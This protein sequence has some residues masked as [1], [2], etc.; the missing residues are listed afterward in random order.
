MKTVN[1][2]ELRDNLKKNLEAVSDNEDLLIVHRPKGKSIV[3]MSLNEFNSLQE[4]F[5]LTRSAA[6]RKRLDAAVENINAR[7]NLEQHNLID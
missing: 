4:T 6:N 5:H 7:I 2:T 3:M 1:Y